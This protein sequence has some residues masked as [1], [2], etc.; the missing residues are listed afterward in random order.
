MS[1]GSRCVLWDFLECRNSQF[2]VFPGN[3]G[4][5]AHALECS[6]SEVF[7]I[8]ASILIGIDQHGVLIEGDL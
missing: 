5:P 4:I 3:S 2:Y 7:Q 6:N 1:A 8:N